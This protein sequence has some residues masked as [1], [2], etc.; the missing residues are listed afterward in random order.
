L[1]VVVELVVVGA[2]EEVNVVKFVE[3]ESVVF[4][5]VLGQLEGFV[6]V[7]AFNFKF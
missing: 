3:R 7:F 1:E 2:T 5:D 4:F 6:G